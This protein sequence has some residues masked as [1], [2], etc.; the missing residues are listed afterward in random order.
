MAQS[1]PVETPSSGVY[2]AQQVIWRGRG[3]TTHANCK[4]FT[5]QN[6]S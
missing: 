1:R 5:S 3:D 4:A 6:A 2:Y